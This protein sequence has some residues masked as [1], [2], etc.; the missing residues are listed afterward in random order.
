MKAEPAEVA[1]LVEPAELAEL[2]EG[3]T[4]VNGGDHSLVSKSTGGGSPSL[5]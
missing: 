5:L 3:A 2:A 4:R 1:E